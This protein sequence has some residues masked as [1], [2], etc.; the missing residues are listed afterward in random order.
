M[1]LTRP[2]GLPAGAITGFGAGF[3]PHQYLLNTGLEQISG[4]VIEHP[5]P[6]A[7]REREVSTK[8]YPARGCVNGRAG[9]GLMVDCTQWNPDQELDLV[10]YWI[11]H[12][13][14]E[15]YITFDAKC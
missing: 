4:E 5:A 3:Q 6:P 11:D 13:Y 15:G 8:L 9:G 7:W 14:P 1:I 10:F 2:K 12:L